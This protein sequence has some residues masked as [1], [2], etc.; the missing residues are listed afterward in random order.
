[1]VTD[2]RESITSNGMELSAIIC[3]LAIA[4]TQAFLVLYGPELVSLRPRRNGWVMAW[5]W[6]SLTANVAE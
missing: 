2:Y 3:R 4:M 5:R 1:M 6:P